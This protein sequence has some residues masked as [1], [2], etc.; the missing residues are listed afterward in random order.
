MI[1]IHSWQ[2]CLCLWTLFWG[3][4][5]LQNHHGTEVD[6]SRKE[7]D[8][9]SRSLRSKSLTRKLVRHFWRMKNV[10][11]LTRL[12][13]KWPQTLT[14]RRKRTSTRVRLLFFYK[15]NRQ[16]QASWK[17][18]EAYETS[19]VKWE[20]LC[21]CC[22]YLRR[23]PSRSSSPRLR[24]KKIAAF[25]LVFHLE[26]LS[27]VSQLLE[28]VLSKAFLLSIFAVVRIHLAE[29]IYSLDH[30]VISRTLL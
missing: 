25:T 19:C 13:Q 11:H 5:A 23:S 2:G 30:F 27:I 29:T 9:I 21:A 4:I 12:P 3:M 6:D 22:L 26:W 24:S 16:K 20:I 8:L 17:A 1:S 18:L 7:K 10:L 15:P 14:R 28:N